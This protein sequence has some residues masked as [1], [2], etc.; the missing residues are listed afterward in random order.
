MNNTVLQIRVDEELKKN[1]N[2]A[3]E[4][5]GLDLSTAIRMF[6]NKT[7]LLSGLPFEV[8]NKRKIVKAKKSFVTK[9]D[10]KSFMNT[11]KNAYD[12]KSIDDY[13]LESRNDRTF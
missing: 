10:L 2:I 6:L 7:V 13:L 12:T 11:E 1:A 5:I 8:N 4:D 9:E 3:L